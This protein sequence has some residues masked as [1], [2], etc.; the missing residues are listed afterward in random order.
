MSDWTLSRR[1]GEADDPSVSDDTYARRDVEKNPRQRIRLSIGIVAAALFFASI[2]API[3]MA[4]S[5]VDEEDRTSVL[6]VGRLDINAASKISIDCDDTT[7]IRLSENRPRITPVIPH[8]QPPRPV[9]PPV[10]AIPAAPRPVVP[11]IVPNPTASRPVVPSVVPTPTAPRPVVPSA[12]ASTSVTNGVHIKWGSPLVPQGQSTY[13]PTK[14][15]PSGQTA[16]PSL[17]SRPGLQPTT[18]YLNGA[19]QVGQ[20]TNS[21]S[22]PKDERYEMSTR[23]QPI[24]NS[25]NGAGQLGQAAGG[26][27]YSTSQTSFYVNT[28]NGT[29]SGTQSFPGTGPGYSASSSTLQSSAYSPAG[30]SYPGYSAS[31]NGQPASLYAPSFSCQYGRCLNG[32]N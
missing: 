8:V 31:G 15:G 6:F 25:A 30:T 28:G 11:S 9:V 3:T 13:S 32:R 22:G 24:T 26:S 21:S 2:S 18:N 14:T 20:G 10:V 29:A 16:L 1:D 4:K 12:V 27:S 19:G 17:Q 5:A 7:F 23:T